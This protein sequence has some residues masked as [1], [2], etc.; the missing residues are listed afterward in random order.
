[1]TQNWAQPPQELRE[2]KQ[3]SQPARNLTR[4]SSAKKRVPS[5][6]TACKLHPRDSKTSKLQ[7]QDCQNA[8]TLLYPCK[9]KTRHLETEKAASAHWCISIWTKHLQI[10]S[11]S[12]PMQ[13][14]SILNKQFKVSKCLLKD[15]HLWNS[16]G[17]RQPVNIKLTQD[18]STLSLS[19]HGS[20]CNFFNLSFGRLPSAFPPWLTTKCNFKSWEW[21][22]F[23]LNPFIL[24]ASSSGRLNKT[25]TTENPVVDSDTLRPGC[26]NLLWLDLRIPFKSRCFTL[27]RWFQCFCF[28]VSPG[29]H[30]RV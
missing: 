15:S 18:H 2:Q 7:W 5:R 10:H 11:K 30:P 3:G 24:D 8:R 1:M 26:L 23:Y 13:P 9:S 25:K 14:L 22:N 16:Q 21:Q 28:N 29:E 19:L 12:S 17:H 6:V 4:R 27:H 20:T